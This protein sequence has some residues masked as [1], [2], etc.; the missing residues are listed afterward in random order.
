[1]TIKLLSIMDSVD[2]INVKK[3]S[4]LALLVEAQQRK[5]EIHYCQAKDLFLSDNKV[6]CL[7]SKIEAHH[8]TKDWVTFLDKVPSKIDLQYFDVILMRKDPPFDLNYLY[9]TYLLEMAHNAGCFIVNN[10]KSIRDSNEKLFATIFTQCCPET[11]VSYNKNLIR[12][13]LNQHKKIILKRLG[14]MGGDSI[15]VLTLDNPNINVTIDVLTHQGTAPVMA[16]RYIEESVKGDK[17]ILMIDGKPYPYALLR[18]PSKDDFRGNLA[19]G[20][21][22]IGCELTDRDLW[23]CEQIGPSLQERGLYFV[24]LDVI[25][26]YLTEINVTSPTCIREIDEAFNVNISAQILDALSN[27]I[28]L[29][30]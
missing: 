24:G 28:K 13:F 11:L 14:S 9:T 19:Q 1:M 15:F 6:K 27:K 12:D 2:A 26:D 23:I 4:T 7:S 17:R 30:R 22:G 3:D 10:P 29:K 21:K 16:Q 18:V 25:G 20:A 5:W 8:H